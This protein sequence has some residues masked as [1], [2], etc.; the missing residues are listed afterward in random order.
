MYQ[1]MRQYLRFPT[2]IVLINNNSKIILNST[3]FN[4]SSLNLQKSIY[5]KFQNHNN[6]KINK[7]L[8]IIV[9]FLELITKNKETNIII[10][11]LTR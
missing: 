5:K 4:I 7:Y 11:L 1:I 3:I 2:Y 8:T 9:R 10:K 6:A